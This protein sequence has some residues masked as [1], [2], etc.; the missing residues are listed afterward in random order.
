M[1]DG[2]PNLTKLRKKLVPTPDG[3]DELKLRTAIVTA[4]NSDG[5][6]DITLAGVTV[7][8]V[9]RLME[10][11]VA[12]GT[13]VQV[14]AYRGSLLVIGRSATSG[15]TASLGLWARAQSTSSL[16][17]ITS[18][19]PVTTG[20]LTNTVT[21]VKNR[22]YECRT[23][24][25]VANNTANTYADLRIYRNTGT[26]LGE[27]YRFPTPVNLPVFNAS[28]SG[29]YFTTAVDVL[30]AVELY[31]STS[32]GSATHFGNAGT[33]RNVEVWD[34]GDISQFPGVPSW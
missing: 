30:G 16:T 34:V 8:G 4:V 32:A 10:A 6:L 12:V 27:W 26:L 1:T 2:S 25:G 28:A 21:F 5:T 29:F 9:P 31:I 18:T 33:P 14:L 13:V 3:Q 11:S 7:A 17:G 15:Q 20:L 22:V 23:H 24:G 19:S